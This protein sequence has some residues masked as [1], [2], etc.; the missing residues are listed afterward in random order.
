MCDQ[1]NAHVNRHCVLSPVANPGEGEKVAPP[2]FQLLYLFAH[3]LLAVASAQ[4]FRGLFCFA[5]APPPFK[6]QTN[7]GSAAA[8]GEAQKEL[9]AEIESFERS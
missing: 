7:P 8:H 9:P 2:P 1:S 4:C 5:F 6:K 3:H